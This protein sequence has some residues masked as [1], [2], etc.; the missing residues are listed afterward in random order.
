MAAAG[1]PV[2][3]RHDISTLMRFDDY[4]VAVEQAFRCYAEGQAWSPGVLHLAVPGGAFH[5]KAAGLALHQ[6]YVAVKINGNFPDNISRAG[7][8]TIQGAIILCDGATGT[9]LAIMDS[10]EITMQRTGATTALAARYLARPESSVA[11][12]CGCGIQGRMQLRALQ[13]VLPLERVYAFDLRYEVATRFATQMTAEL[14]LPVT[15]IRSV[16][17]G[18]PRSD[19]IATCTPARQPVL[20]RA[21]VPGGAFIAAV[22]ADSPEKQEL[23]PA[24]LGGNTVV[25]DLLEQCR[26]MGELHHAL[27]AGLLG[28]EDVY[29]ELGEIVA[30]HKPGRTARDEIIV[31]DSTGTA[32]QDVASAAAV[33]ERACQAGRGYRVDLGGNYPVTNPTAPRS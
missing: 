11:T 12:I 4:L 3:T 32:L 8:P 27:A 28:R 22:G 15:P 7:L 9:P 20:H 18:G 31:F 33:Y 10:I 6:T 23:D 19:V 26:S 5:V 29:A 25:V 24:L 13:H 30:G 21:D 2:L 1:M 17:E 16:S 14:G